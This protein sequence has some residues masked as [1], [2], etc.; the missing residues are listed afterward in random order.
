MKDWNADKI[1]AVGMVVAFLAIV[2]G[3]DVVAVRNGDMTI[4]SLGKEI[5]I[6]L[7]GYMGRGAVQSVTSKPQEQQSQTAQTLGKVSE[8]ASNGQQIVNAIDNLKDTFKK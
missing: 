3:V 8:V 5:A 4:A 2:L 6:G 1:L 7:F